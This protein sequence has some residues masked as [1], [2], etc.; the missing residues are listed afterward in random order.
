MSRRQVLTALV[1]AAALTTSILV[2]PAG[3]KV[4]AAACTPLSNVEAI[5]DDS[6]S[7]A[8]TDP[9]T[10]RAQAVKLIIQ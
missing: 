4:H 1:G 9:Q 5:V 2:A 7:M 6:G 8:G 3:A 10:L